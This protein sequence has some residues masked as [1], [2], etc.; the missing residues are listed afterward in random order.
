MRMQDLG[1][2]TT[3]IQEIG[4]RVKKINLDNI[5][6]QKLVQIDKNLKELLWQT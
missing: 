6:E 1:L 3:D 2:Y 4:K 5:F